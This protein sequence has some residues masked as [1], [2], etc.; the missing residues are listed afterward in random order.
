MQYPAGLA[1]ISS[2]ISGVYLVTQTTVRPEHMQSR[3]IKSE[4]GVKSRQKPHLPQE[5]FIPNDESVPTAK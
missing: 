2:Q 3:S 4:K 1:R 5:P